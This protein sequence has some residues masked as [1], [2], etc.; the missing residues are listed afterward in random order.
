MKHKISIK[1]TLLTLVL[2]CF[3][4]LIFS[5]TKVEI[6]K[7]DYSEENAKRKFENHRYNKADYCENKS[8][9][10]EKCKFWVIPQYTL[11]GSIDTFSLPDN[12]IK[13]LKIN[14]VI[15]HAYLLED[16]NYHG[17]I[18][19]NCFL[20]GITANNRFENDKYGEKEVKFLKDLHADYIFIVDNLFGI[21]Y[22]KN[23]SLMIANIV[24][25][26]TYN[27]TNYIEDKNYNLWN[28]YENN[29]KQQIIKQ[30]GVA[31]ICKNKLLFVNY[32]QKWTSGFFNAPFYKLWVYY[33]KDPLSRPY[34]KYKY[35][36]HRFILVGE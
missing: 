8:W 13:H 10:I 24:E 21:F 18:S 26:K 27:F 20:S 25:F 4:T 14:K 31:V 32:M 16:G 34:L 19:I 30:K 23:D 1:K 9:S 12:F 22:I 3:S 11:T 35:R 29:C 6:L 28:K 5:Q 17:T 2:I 36:Q 33:P 15:N 7:K